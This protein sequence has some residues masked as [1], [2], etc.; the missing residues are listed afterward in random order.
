MDDKSGYI[1]SFGGDTFVMVLLSIIRE[2]PPAFFF[3]FTYFCFLLHNL[4]HAF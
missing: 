1:F 4:P 3:T 2:V